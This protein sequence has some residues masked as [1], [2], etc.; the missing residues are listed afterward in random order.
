MNKLPISPNNNL[1]NTN[2][3]VTQL[4]SNMSNLNK[5]TFSTYM[6]ADKDTDSVIASKQSDPYWTLTFGSNDSIGTIP[7]LTNVHLFTV[8]HWYLNDSAAMEHAYDT[9]GKLIAY[10]Y[11]QW[12]IGAWSE[13]AKA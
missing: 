2:D 7:T 4:D 5:K 9:T 12:W 3:K 11:K 8:I 1:S 13:W 10:R 6:S